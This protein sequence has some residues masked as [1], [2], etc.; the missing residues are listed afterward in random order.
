[1]WRRHDERVAQRAYAD[2]A[3]WRERAARAEAEGEHGQAGAHEAL[4]EDEIDAS[5]RGPFSGR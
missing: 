4:L 1:M 5:F 3:R 2:D